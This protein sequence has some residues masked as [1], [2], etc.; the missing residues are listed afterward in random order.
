[1]NG[2]TLRVADIAITAHFTPGHTPG[3]TSWTWTS[4]DGDHCQNMVYADTDGNI[5][6]VAT[7][8]TPVRKGWDGLLPVPGAPGTHEWQGFLE[9]RRFY[10]NA[11]AAGR[12]VIFT[13]D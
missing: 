2:Q 10:K 7:A 8:L 3:G 5:G 1:M 12:A 6:W 9:V 13:V 11:A 4:C